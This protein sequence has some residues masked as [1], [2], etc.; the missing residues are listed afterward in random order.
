MPSS[1]QA[2]GKVL[3]TNYR[4]EDV[5]TMMTKVMSRDIMS[6]SVMFC[7]VLSC[8]GE[9]GGGHGLRVKLLQAGVQQQEADPLPL[10]HAHLQTLPQAEVTES[11]KHCGDGYIVYCLTEF[12]IN[13]LPPA[14][15]CPRCVCAAAR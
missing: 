8:A 9:P 2:L 3:L 12:R 4:T 6:C 5:L 13:G 1:P 15:R 14:R 7:H 11:V 10:L